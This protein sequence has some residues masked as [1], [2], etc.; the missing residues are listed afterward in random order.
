MEMEMEKGTGI[1]HPHSQDSLCRALLLALFA[2]AST[3]DSQQS[4]FPLKALPSESSRDSTQHSHDYNSSLMPNNSGSFHLTILGC[5][6]GPITGTTCSFLLKPAS[7]DYSDLLLNYHN[8]KQGQRNNATTNTTSTNPTTTSSSPDEKTRN[9]SKDCL[10]LIDAGSLLNSLVQMFTDNSTF[11]NSLLSMYQ[12]SLKSWTQYTNETNM[13]VSSSPLVSTASPV[14]TAVGFPTPL[15]LASQFANMINSFLITHSHLDHTASLVINSPV[16]QTVKTIFGLGSTLKALKAHSFNNSTWPELPSFF[17][18]SQLNSGDI[19]KINPFFECQIY[20]VSHGELEKTESGNSSLNEVNERYES[21]GFLIKNLETEKYLLIFGDIESDSVSKLDYNLKIWRSVSDLLVHDQ[22]NSIVI[23]CSSVDQETTEHLF[24]HMTP[25][26]LIYEFL[27]LR[28]CCFKKIHQEESE[29]IASEAS[30]QRDINVAISA[31]QETSSSSPQSPTPFYSKIN[32]FFRFRTPSHSNASH[33]S[34]D[35]HNN[36]NNDSHNQLN[37]KNS[38]NINVYDGSLARRRSTT[39]NTNTNN[40]A[41]T[42]KRRSISLGNYY[43]NHKHNSKH[44]HQQFNIGPDENIYS[45][46]F[47]Q[48]ESQPLKGLNVII[49][50][51]KETFDGHDPRQGILEQLNVLNQRYNLQVNFSIGLPGLTYQL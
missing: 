48:L 50:H 51:V 23:E 29:F 39:T 43:N 6:G 10:V 14:M 40:N 16:F 38:R 30:L 17:K 11:V 4:L 36:K 1:Y 33:N 41:S 2:T 19:S 22:L 42:Y 28:K 37:D 32:S 21:S 45:D 7:Q 35:S 5:S 31:V 8:T 3:K 46:K 26:F 12:D 15:Q 20:Q 27:T 18:Y 25:S 13:S 44:H 49:I 34:H 24:G 9:L 47:T